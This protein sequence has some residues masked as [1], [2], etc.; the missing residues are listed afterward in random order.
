MQPVVLLIFPFF[1]LQIPFSLG[2]PRERRIFPIYTTSHL[3][4]SGHLARLDVKFGKLMSIPWWEHPPAA[5][6]KEALHFHQYL[7]KHQKHQPQKN[8]QIQQRK[9]ERKLPGVPI[10]GKKVKLQPRIR[11]KAA[12]SSFLTHGACG[13]LAARNV[14][15][16][17][18]VKPGHAQDFY[19]ASSRK[20]RPHCLNTNPN[21]TKCH[22]QLK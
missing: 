3:E 19:I 9:K 1:I 16:K 7:T 8:P 18:F 10:M 15:G 14:P 11:P 5:S 4:P 21:T 6:A 20:L 17:F 22:F 12:K 2:F 13:V